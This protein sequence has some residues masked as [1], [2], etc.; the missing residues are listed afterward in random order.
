MLKRLGAGAVVGLVGSN[1]DQCED[2][3]FRPVS[4]GGLPDSLLSNARLRGWLLLRVHDGR[5]ERVRA[6]SVCRLH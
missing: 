2:S 3:G 1:S 5:N 6:A 4:P